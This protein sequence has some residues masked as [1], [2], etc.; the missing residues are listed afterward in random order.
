MLNLSLNRNLITRDHL[1]TVRHCFNQ[2]S[3]KPDLLSW[4]VLY[5]V[6]IQLP[7]ARYPKTLKKRTYLCQNI[8][9]LA[10]LFLL[11]D[12]QFGYQMIA[13]LDHFVII[14]LFMTL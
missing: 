8:E 1:L 4:T 7:E 13:K 14:F 9:W 6:N 3:E 2:S 5:T 12:N 11:S 10:I